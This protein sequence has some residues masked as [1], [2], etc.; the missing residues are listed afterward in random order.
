M[1]LVDLEH[2]DRMA[3][4]LTQHAAAL[5]EGRRRLRAQASATHW[6]S[7]ASRAFDCSLE[8]LLAELTHGASRLSHSADVLRQHSH[9]A[10]NR[11]AELAAAAGAVGSVLAPAGRLARGVLDAG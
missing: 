11:A 1:H 5:A 3:A 9:R 2:A 6:D 7:P 8:A 10:A 4:A